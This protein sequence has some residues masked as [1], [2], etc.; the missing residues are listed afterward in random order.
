VHKESLLNVGIQTRRGKMIKKV[1]DKK[2]KKQPDN[3][4]D[5]E[6]HINQ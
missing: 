5:K 1:P 6:N 2:E 3:Q 4:E